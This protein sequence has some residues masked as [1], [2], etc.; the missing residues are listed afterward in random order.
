L[1][2]PIAFDH[3]FEVLSRVL[4][5]PARTAYVTVGDDQV[6]VRF[7]WG[8]RST[9]PRAAVRGAR[10]DHR[11]RSPVSRGAHGW[12]GRWLVNGA[13]APLVEIDLDP[14]QLAHVL[15]IAIHV[16]QLIVSVDDADRLAKELVA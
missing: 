9:F 16:H 8:F 7:G 2:F 13:G 1:R 3:W 5:I 15:G 12:R 14:R 4:L 11:R 10:V 6:D